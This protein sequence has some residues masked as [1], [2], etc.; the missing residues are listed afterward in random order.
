MEKENDVLKI[1][2]EAK[3]EIELRFDL[4]IKELNVCSWTTNDIKTCL[5][6]IIGKFEPI[7]KK[8]R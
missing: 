8:V 6:E 1:L 2:K 5:K 4:P 7:A 3:E